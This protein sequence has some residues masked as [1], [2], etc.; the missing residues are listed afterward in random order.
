MG[1]IQ[2]TATQFMAYLGGLAQA[3]PPTLSEDIPST[4]NFTVTSNSDET[5]ALQVRGAS[6]LFRTYPENLQRIGVRLLAFLV[7]LSR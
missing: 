7:V 6:T 1:A 4:T 3:N 2:K 5:E